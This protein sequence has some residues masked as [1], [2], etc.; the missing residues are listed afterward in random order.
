MDA[1]AK[2]EVTC[3]VSVDVEAVWVGEAVRV[4]VCGGKGQQDGLAGRDGD[5]ADGDVLCRK[6][7]DGQGYRAVVAGK[8]LHCGTEARRVGAELGLL[9]GVAKQ[10]Q[11]CVSDEVNG[12]LV[13]SDQDE[14]GQGHQLV[15]AQPVFLI[16]YG[17]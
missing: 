7:A 3:S 1:V 12:V 17:D 16:A 10:G 14:E 9:V 2:G 5:A 8:L 11:D 4:P 13:P 6:P 15:L